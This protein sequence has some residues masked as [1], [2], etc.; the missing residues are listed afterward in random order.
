M[1]ICAAQYEAFA[2]I[3]DRVFGFSRPTRILLLGLDAAGKTSVLYKLKLGE[4]V[5]RAQLSRRATW[6]NSFGAHFSDAPSST[7][8]R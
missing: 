3:Y 2:K 6:R 7:R 8:L 1:L 5:R 4:L